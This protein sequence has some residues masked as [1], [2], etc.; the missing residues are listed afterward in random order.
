MNLH[1]SLSLTP[2]TSEGLIVAFFEEFDTRNRLAISDNIADVYVFFEDK[3]PMKI[4][5]AI[6]KCHIKELKFETEEKTAEAEETIPAE[7]TTFT[8]QESTTTEKVTSPAVEPPLVE[9]A[10]SPT[11]EVAPA[12]EVLPKAKTN[13]P[14]LDAK[15]ELT[16][17]AEHSSSFEDFVTSVA[18]LL[19]FNKRTQFFADLVEAATKASKASWNEIEANLKAKS[20]SYNY[21]KIC[22]NRKVTE[23]FEGYTLLSLIKLVIQYKDFAFQQ[24][25]TTNEQT[26]S[27]PEIPALKEALLTV[28]KTLPVESRVKHVLFAM[29]LESEDEKAKNEIL[30]LAITAM[31]LKEI[32]FANLFVKCNIPMQDTAHARAAFS[33]FLEKCGQKVKVLNFLKSLQAEIMLADEIQAL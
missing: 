28:D 18:K 3:P 14:F 21:D 29:G 27:M 11:K 30:D 4:V 15:A 7:E 22:C 16:K 32:N 9:E 10:T 13:E 26:I 5:A 24:T 1:A 8:T 31:S 25:A 19:D 20:K 12:E 33:T 23:K 6:S 2:E 17:I